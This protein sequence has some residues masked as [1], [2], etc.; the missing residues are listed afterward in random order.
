MSLVIFSTIIGKMKYITQFDC[1]LFYFGQSYDLFP[2]LSNDKYIHLYK[3]YFVV[4]MKQFII[5]SITDLFHT[6][7]C[8]KTFISFVTDFTYFFS[9][10]HKKKL[11]LFTTDDFTVVVFCYIQCFFHV[12]HGIYIEL[13]IYVRKFIFTKV[14]L[15]IEHTFCQQN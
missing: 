1:N 7:S 15:H 2:F 6:T 11:W 13:F 5:P 8:K 14:F 10:H 9:I 12:A 4:C 3:T